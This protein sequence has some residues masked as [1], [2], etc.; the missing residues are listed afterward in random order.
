MICCVAVPTLVWLFYAAGKASLFPPQPGVREE[1]FGCCSQ[2]LV[3]KRDYLPN[4]ISFL[5]LKVRED[6][7]PRCDM[8]TRDFAYVWGLARLSSYPMMVQH[9]GSVS[10]TFTEAREAQSITSMAFEYLNGEKL[11]RNHVEMVQKLF[12]KS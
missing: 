2:A 1:F 11:R 9:V 3:F 8:L 12:G 10:A 7:E 6:P 5:Q 4:L